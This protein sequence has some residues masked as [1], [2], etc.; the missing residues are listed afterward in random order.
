MSRPSTSHRMDNRLA[1]MNK[2]SIARK[3]LFI[4]FHTGL[5]KSFFGPFVIFPIGV[6]DCRSPLARHLNVLLWTFRTIKVDDSD[7]APL[8]RGRRRKE[9][10][11]PVIMLHDIGHRSLV[12]L[13]DA[14]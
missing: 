10:K 8:P 7:A 14:R 2:I 13:P 6:P 9:G 4:D 5:F 11:F 3:A 12:I 1:E